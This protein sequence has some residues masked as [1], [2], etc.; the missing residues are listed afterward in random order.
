MGALFYI[1]FLIFHVNPASNLLMICYIISLRIWALSSS[2][3]TRVSK[4]PTAKIPNLCFNST[5]IVSFSL[6]E[7][8]DLCFNSITIV[9]FE[10]KPKR[11]SSA[12]NRRQAFRKF[13]ERNKGKHGKQEK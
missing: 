12:S 5:T 10:K 6:A 9:T 13:A 7:R 1:T 3:K 11:N 4:L 2:A 8:N